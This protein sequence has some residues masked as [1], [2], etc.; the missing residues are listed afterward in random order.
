MCGIVGVS[1]PTNVHPNIIKALLILAQSRGSDATGIAT[2]DV[3]IKQADEALKFVAKLQ[4]PESGTIIGHTRLGTVGSKVLSENAHPFKYGDIVGAH[5]GGITNYNDIAREY[6]QKFNVDSEAAFYLLSI[7]KPKEAIAK[8]QGGMALSWID[9]KNI[10][11]LYRHTNPI[12]VGKLNGGIVYGSEERYLD[13]V[14]A[15]EIE[16]LKEHTLYKYKDGKLIETIEGIE[17]KKYTY[18]RGST[19]RFQSTNDYEYTNDKGVKSVYVQVSSAPNWAYE[20]TDSAGYTCRAWIDSLAR[21]YVYV[22]TNYAY[23]G[24]GFYHDIDDTWIEKVII[25]TNKMENIK[26]L[27][28]KYPNVYDKFNIKKQKMLLLN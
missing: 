18:S 11:H 28:E 25:D 26:W 19:T 17:P 12:Y 24:S 13:V 15:T 20:F 3:V 16:S 22:E 23:A 4:V 7:M 5:N 21:N 6:D 8:L 1:M 27:E 14:K 2:K 9:K 10:L